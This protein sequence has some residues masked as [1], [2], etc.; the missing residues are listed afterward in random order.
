[1]SVY[2]G[3]IDLAPGSV[4]GAVA[5]FRVKMGFGNY[6]EFDYKQFLLSKGI[7][8]KAIVKSRMT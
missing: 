4:V 1:M 7:V 6:D 8:M 3:V 2:R 5:L